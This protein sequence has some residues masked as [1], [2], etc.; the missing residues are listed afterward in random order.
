MHNTVKNLALQYCV[1][2][3]TVPSHDN[4]VSLSLGNHDGFTPVKCQSRGLACKTFLFLAN[5][6]DTIFKALLHHC[7]IPQHRYVANIALV[8]VFQLLCSTRCLLMMLSVTFT[9]FTHCCGSS[10]LGWVASRRHSGIGSSL[11]W[12]RCYW[13]PYCYWLCSWRVGG[14]GV[15]LVWCC[16]WLGSRDSWVGDWKSLV[17]LIL[18]AKANDA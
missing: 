12:W 10:D 7:F 1:A 8:E 15:A 18:S 11:R 17:S 9:A 3:I 4:Q 14:R 6:C 13:L 5:C 16:N 2:T